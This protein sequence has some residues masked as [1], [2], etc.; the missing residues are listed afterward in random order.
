[1]RMRS[2]EARYPAASSFQDQNRNLGMNNPEVD[3]VR[4]P[5]AKSVSE[6]TIG[7]KE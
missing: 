7:A 1:M 5:N 6:F 4:M 3:A 2:Q